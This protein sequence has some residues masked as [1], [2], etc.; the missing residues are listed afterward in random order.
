MGILKKEECFIG[1]REIRV[2]NG[3]KVRACKTGT[4]INKNLEKI[5][6][7]LCKCSSNTRIKGPSEDI[8]IG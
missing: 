3:R 4:L 7:S 8:L 2:L 6:L 1:K 5:S